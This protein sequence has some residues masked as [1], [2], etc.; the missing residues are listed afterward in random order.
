MKRLLPAVLIILLTGTSYAQDLSGKLAALGALPI[1]P[2]SADWLLDATAF[3]AGVYRGAGPSDL[4]LTNGLS[5]RSFRLSPNLACYSFRNLLTG[6]E[7]IRA[8]K[9]EALVTIN[10]KETPIGGLKGQFEYGYIK[11]EWMDRFTAE[12]GSFKLQDFTVN[13]IR[14][15]LEWSPKR[16]VPE[17]T[18]PPGG[19]EVTFT[20]TS[21]NF[22][23]VVAE[24]HYELYDGIPLMSKWLVLRNNSGRQLAVNHFVNEYLATVEPEASVETIGNWDVPNMLVCSDFAFSGMNTKSSNQSTFWLRDTL[25]TSQVDYGLNTPCLL[26]CKPPL[27]PGQQIG[28]AE[29]FESFRIFELLFDSYDHE[30]KGLSVRRMYRTLA[31]WSLE[32]P[33]FLHLTSTDPLV[34]KTAVDQCVITGFEMII[35]SFGSGLNMENTDENYIS[36]MKEMVAYANSRGIEIGGYSL[37]ASRRINDDE[38]VI[39]PLTGKTGGAIFGNSPCLESNWG[40]QYFRNLTNFIQKTGFALLEHDGS[41]PGDPCASLKHPGHKGLDDSQWNQWKEITDF[42]KWC[43]TKDIYLNVPDWYFLSGSNKTGIGYRE[44]NWSLPRDRQIMLG[45]QN[46]YDGTWEKTPSMGWTFVPLTEYQGGGSAA[47]LEPLSEHLAEYQSHL[48]QNFGA[49]VQACYRGSRLYDTDQ[50]KDMVINWVN[51]YKRYRLIL[52][53]DIIHLRRAD[54]RDWDGFMHVNPQLKEK[55]FLMLFNPMNQPVSRTIKIPLYYTGLTTKAMIREKEG[56][57]ASYSLNERQ[58]I[59]LNVTIPS[60]GFTWYVIE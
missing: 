57:P 43:R 10:G 35:L 58:E 14:A 37:L 47:T 24:V 20:F 23:D 34:M 25:Y 30:R 33:I 15:R 54:G 6:Q 5:E 60:N 49:G 3:R 56:N 21:V 36:G 9:P 50:T 45:R 31:P 4:V 7:M 59:L 17:T 27:G 48:A 2:A 29:K 55:G 1:Q 38:D 19:K 53:S 18:W 32:N 44:T 40:I 8:I 22:P 16:W 51:W 46:L 11:Y 52:N 39:N 26:Q 41:Y 13:D 12:T 42:Y 28:P